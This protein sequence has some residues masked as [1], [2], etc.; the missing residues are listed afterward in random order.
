MAE[1]ITNLHPDG[2]KN[3]NLYP[4]IKKENIPNKSIDIS[5]LD[6]NVLSLIG[7]LKPSGTDTSS[8]ILAFTSNKGIYVATDNGHW[9]YW[10]G[11]QYADG[12][13]YQ[14]DPRY[15]ELEEEIVE[16]E[17]KVIKYLNIT[18]MYE[19]LEGF[20]VSNSKPLGFISN[21]DM[22]TKMPIK[23]KIGKT[24]TLTRYSNGYIAFAQANELVTPGIEV[25]VHDVT[26]DWQ[27]L[28]TNSN[29]TFTANGEYLYLSYAKNTKLQLEEGSTSSAYTEKA[30]ELQPILVPEPK[31]DVDFANY[32]QS[33]YNKQMFSYIK[34]GELVCNKTNDGMNA[35]YTGVEFNEIPLSITCK[36]K[37]PVADKVVNSSGTTT[38]AG[39]VAIVCNPNGLNCVN[40]I[41]ANSL[42][43]SLTDEWLKLDLLG[44]EKGRYYWFNFFTQQLPSK[45]PYDNQTEVEL[46]LN[47]NA[48]TQTPSVNIK[49]GSVNKTYSK[50]SYNSTD[51]NYNNETEVDFTSHPYSEFIGK[52]CTIEHFSNGNMDNY[53]MPKFTYFGIKGNDTKSY[54][55][56]YF[57]RQD[58]ALSTMPTGQVYHCISN[59]YKN[60]H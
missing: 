14:T 51:S 18:K 44:N 54:A 22:I 29:I 48:D 10:N 13:V 2:D 8:N 30:Y 35:Q 33:Q 12:G 26:T 41:T 27:S 19:D 45:I 28:G 55:W 7:S 58:G 42:H 20:Y 5:K 40:D 34:N 1:I 53:V 47:I 11:T 38:N 56:D 17:N 4:N 50:H 59:V 46:T 57:K 49:Y 23:L 9:Y 15:D 39:T 25:Y 36:F 43:L 16:L 32:L 37:M 21:K 3:T 52:Y 31:I 60:I 24:Y 6:D